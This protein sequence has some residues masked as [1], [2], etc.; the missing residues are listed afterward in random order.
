MSK[1]M[2]VTLVKSRHGRNPKHQATIASLGLKKLGSSVRVPITP[3]Y[4][5]MVKKVSYLISVV[6]GEE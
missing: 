1:F 2:Q 5:G 3:D 6:I 4:L